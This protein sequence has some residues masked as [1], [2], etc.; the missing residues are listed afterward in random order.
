[1]SG[2]KSNLSNLFRTLEA[3]KKIQRL[4]DYK[5]FIWLKFYLRE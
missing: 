5:Y 1:M 3:A 2:Q 4:M